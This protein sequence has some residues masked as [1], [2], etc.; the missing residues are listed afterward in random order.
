MAAFGMPG[1][2]EIWVILAIALLLFGPAQLPQL[3]KMF[4]KS[5]KALRDGL[6]D[7]VDDAVANKTPQTEPDSAGQE[8]VPRTPV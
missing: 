4:G 7:D 2:M 5:A 6:A 8:D 3:A 1:G